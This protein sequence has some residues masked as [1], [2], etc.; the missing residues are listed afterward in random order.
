MSIRN[1]IAVGLTVVAGA[2]AAQQTNHP[3]GLGVNPNAG[4][5]VNFSWQHLPG[6]ARD[7]GVGGGVPWVIGTYPTYGSDFAIYRYNGAGWT[8]IPGGAVR[9]DVD[10]S[11]NAWVVSSAHALYHFNGQQFVA[12]PGVSATDV[13]IGADG[14]VWVIGADAVGND[15]SIYRLVKDAWQKVPGAAGVRIDVDF[16]GNAWVVNSAH[17]IF[18]WTGSSWKQVPGAA[19]DIGIGS[20]TNGAYEGIYI[21]DPSG[22]IFH[23]T[24]GGWGSVP[25]GLTNIS[26]DQR[27]NPWGVN[28][29]YEIYGAIPSY[30]TLVATG[31][32][33]SWK[34]GV[35]RS[36]NYPA[37][38]PCPTD[39]YTV[40]A[41]VSFVQITA[42]GGT[43]RN[44][45]SQNVIG[46]L[47]LAGS[48]ATDNSDPGVA[49]GF[50]NV[51]PGHGGRGAI[52]QA[53]FQVTPGQRLYVTT[54]VNGDDNYKNSGRWG[55]GGSFPGGGSGQTPGGGYSMVSVQP[56]VRQNPNDPNYC[57]IQPENILVV[58][59]GGGG[60]GMAGGAGGG[61]T[62]GDAGLPGQW[63]VAGGSGGG[64]LSGGG[65][66]GGGQST[67]GGVGS[68]PGCGSE[69]RWGGSYLRGSDNTGD[70]GA[71]GGGYYGGGGGGGGDCMLETG[72]GGGGGGSSYVSPLTLH[73]TAGIDTNAN[74][75]V[76]IQPLK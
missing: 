27:G 63:A 37:N 41:G 2:A 50:A 21:V 46:N 14:S 62:G 51:N 17:Q 43:G 60:A 66:G 19:V 40:P 4:N 10:P 18:Q 76:V 53:I 24:S 6:A 25:G 16:R 23:R 45:D 47:G 9:I 67:G 20:P 26:V 33:K 56:P 35:G 44:G 68:H 52:V 34:G 31:T 28:A 1:C 65:G 54:G 12:V 49:P 3:Y 72:P 13:G 61:G 36:D 32:P 55:E 57:W 75:G 7:I 58:A 74:P 8:Q 30:T 73:V 29:N 22:R 64:A 59:G 69:G 5:A 38:M 42:T 48:T 15:H 71:G 11:G 70:G 39:T